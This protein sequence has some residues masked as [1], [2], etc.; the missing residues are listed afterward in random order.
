MVVRVGN[1]QQQQQQQQ[2]M[3]GDAPARGAK[4][5]GQDAPTKG[6]FGCGREK[7]QGDDGGYAKTHSDNEVEDDA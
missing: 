2:K 1:R 3:K 4:G 7:S 6:A 5:S